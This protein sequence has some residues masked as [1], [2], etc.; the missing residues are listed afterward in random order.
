MGPWE[1][2]MDGPGRERPP[3]GTRCDA[4]SGLFDGFLWNYESVTLHDGIN[5]MQF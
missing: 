5:C 2:H 1:W 4:I 3:R